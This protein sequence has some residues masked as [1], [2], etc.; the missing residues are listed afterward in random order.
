MTKILEWQQITKQIAD[1]N[2]PF[3]ANGY[4][5]AGE[6]LVITGESGAGKSTLLR[7]LARLSS[8]E[9]GQIYYK[10]QSAQEISPMEWR[11]KIRYLA[12]KPVF[13]PGTVAENLQQPFTFAVIKKELGYNSEEVEN[14]LEALGLSANILEREA[15]IISGGEGARLALIKAL[16]IHPEILLLDEPTANLDKENQFRLIEVLKKWLADKK[17]R[18]IIMVSHNSENLDFGF[19]NIR[20]IHI[21]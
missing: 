14:Y 17:D 16:I 7:M 4:L 12:Q 1:R 13:F 10:G 18:G 15:G 11:R 9:T 20:Q 5:L 6:I 21:S 8:S 2:K 19:E 3:Q